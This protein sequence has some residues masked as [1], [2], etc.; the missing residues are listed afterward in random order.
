MNAAEDDEICSREG[1]NG[2]WLS[3]WYPETHINQKMVTEA[4]RKE[5]D[6][7]KRMKVYRVVTRES[8]ERDEEAKMISIKWVVTIK[9][10]E[11]HPIAKA[12]LLASEFST[13]DKKWRVVCRNA[14]IDGHENSDF[15]GDDEMRDWSEKVNHAGRCEDSRPVWR[16]KEVVVH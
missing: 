13:G 15:Q 10:T 8:T 1:I 7:F 2:E 4:K 11:E 3:S 5:M 6:R 14:W 16:R 9:S 12:R